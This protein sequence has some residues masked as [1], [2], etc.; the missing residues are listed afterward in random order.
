MANTAEL[1][2]SLFDLY[3][4]LASKLLDDKKSPRPFVAFFH[5]G[6]NIPNSRIAGICLTSDCQV[7]FLLAVAGG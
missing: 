7:L 6:I 4:E 3:P 5:N 1:F 2:D